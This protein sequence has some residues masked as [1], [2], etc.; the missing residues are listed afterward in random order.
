MPGPRWY[1]L[2]GENESETTRVESAVMLK[3]SQQ[4]MLLHVGL[5]APA[6]VVAHDP[7]SC[8]PN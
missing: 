3:M 2:Y 1:R 6:V 7:S 4:S 5:A 8:S